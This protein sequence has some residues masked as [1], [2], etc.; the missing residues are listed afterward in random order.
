M[1]MRCTLVAANAAAHSAGLANGLSN[2]ADSL[3]SFGRREDALEAAQES[4]DL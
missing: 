1:R 3:G 4:V 2:F